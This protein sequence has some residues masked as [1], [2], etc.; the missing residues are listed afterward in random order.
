M[1]TANGGPGEDYSV[2]GGTTVTTACRSA[3]Q[4]VA[5]G[6]VYDAFGRTTSQPGGVTTRYFAKDIARQQTTATQR[7]TWKLDA[8][9][10][11]RT[12]TAENRTGTT[13]TQVGSKTN[14]YKRDADSPRW[15]VED[16]ATAAVTRNVSPPLRRSVRHD[17]RDRRHGAPF[18]HHPR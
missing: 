8:A 1:T 11:I 18:H 3:D 7:Q 16:N 14:H 13:W 6:Y 17:G 9:L 5:A 2:S 10:R 12:W 4:S 15:I